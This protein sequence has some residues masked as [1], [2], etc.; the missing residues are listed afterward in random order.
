[1]KIIDIKTAS[2]NIRYPIHLVKILTDSGLYGI[3]EAYN[4]A[5]VVDHIRAIKSRIIGED[6][7][8]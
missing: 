7:P 1:M 5:G 8:G 2:V 6:P 3:G 4:R